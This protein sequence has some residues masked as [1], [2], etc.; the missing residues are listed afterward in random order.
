MCDWELR[1]P[2]PGK[3]YKQN[4]W[5]F[6]RLSVHKSSGTRAEDELGKRPMCEQEFIRW[7]TTLAPDY[8][9][10]SSIASFLGSSPGLNERAAQ[11]KW[12]RMLTDG[13]TRKDKRMSVNP[14]GEETGEAGLDWTRLCFS[15]FFL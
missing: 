12:L 5:D 3:G 14:D 2:L 9:R 10:S 6:S 8:E 11:R 15:E 4:S 13:V 1:C 7:F